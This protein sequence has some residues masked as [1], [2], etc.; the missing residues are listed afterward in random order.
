MITIWSGGQTGVDIASLLAAYAVGLPT[1][2]Y[3][4]KTYKQLT[5]DN[6]HLL[7]DVFKLTALQTNSYKERTWKNVEESDCTV[8]FARDFYSVGEVCTFN[9]IEHFNKPYLDIDV[10]Y[11]NMDLVNIRDLAKKRGEVYNFI[12]DKKIV[13]FAGNSEKTAPGIC[14]IVT[15]FLI[16]I[17]RKCVELRK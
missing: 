8:R 1:G 3:A 10:A 15:E 9:A 2:G 16:P 4:T 17:F 11:L 5:G 7:R 6:P 12:K 13:N 14:A